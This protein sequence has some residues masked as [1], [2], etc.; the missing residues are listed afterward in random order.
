MKSPRVARR[1]RERR[2]SLAR[3]PHL[4]AL[5]YRWWRARAVV[6]TPSQARTMVPWH[7]RQTMEIEDDSNPEDDA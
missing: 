2:G 4:N 7:G 3:P 1:W 5:T 6:R